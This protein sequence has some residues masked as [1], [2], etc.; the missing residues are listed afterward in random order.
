MRKIVYVGFAFK[1]HKNT[2]AG[3]HQIADYVKY[4][5]HIDCNK[6]ME[7]ANTPPKNLLDRIAKHI[8]WRLFGFCAVPWFIIRCIYMGIKRNDL[9]FHF[10]YGEN[11]YFNFT[12]FIRSGNKIVCTFHQP[13]DYFKARR[14]GKRLKTIDK[15]ILVGNSE[16]GDFQK[17]LGKGKVEFIP[18]GICTDF[19]CPDYGIS[20]KHL[21]LTV[22]NWLRDYEFANIV[23]H[24]LLD[25]D[26]DLEI[27]VVANADRVKDIK[28][29]PRIQFMSGITDESL[30]QLYRTC[31]VLF[32]PLKR[33]TAN[34]SLLEAAACGCNIVIAS[35]FQ[36]NSYIPDEFL[37]LCSTNVDE[38]VA[39]INEVMGR[40][41]NM[42]LANYT[43]AHYSWE[44][45]GVEIAQRLRNTY[46]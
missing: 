22:G 45:I 8:Y 10:I 41:P 7:E 24:K 40:K 31:S 37:S 18:H 27:V 16:L 15:V 36:D 33:Y 29:H 44:K 20:Q 46:F 1:H 14:W 5:Y 3:Y 23:Y 32:L 39:L 25:E 4:D 26:E 38:C 21:L 30:R 9:T 13:I 11:T 12:H 19:Y 42:E 35:N 2:H 6:Y 43:K 17:I 28:K 34:N